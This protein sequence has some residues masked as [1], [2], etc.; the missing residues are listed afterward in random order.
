MF[1]SKLVHE[2]AGMHLLLMCVNSG[3][4]KTIAAKISLLT[5]VNS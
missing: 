1:Y 3:F 5:C 4:P 2:I